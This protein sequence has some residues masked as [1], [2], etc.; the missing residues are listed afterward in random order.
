MSSY[1]NAQTDAFF[2]DASGAASRMPMGTKRGISPNPSRPS[3]A[4]QSHN[5]KQEDRQNGT[6]T[7]SQPLPS[8]AAGHNLMTQVTLVTTWLRDSKGARWVTFNDIADYLSIHDEQ[9]RLILQHI[10]R[11]H[12][13]VE[14]QKSP[15]NG[16]EQYRFKPVHN[17]RSAEDLL[18]VLQQ[19]TTADGIKMQE[20]REGWAGALE[21]VSSLA[22]QGLVLVTRNK[23]DS[24][25][26]R[27]WPS[28]PSL[29]H[30][31]DPEF[32]DI[33]AKLRVPSAKAD[34]RRELLDFGLMPTAQ[35]K[36]VKPLQKENGRKKRTR[37]GGK[38]TNTHM[39]AVLQNFDHLRK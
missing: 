27:V 2:K 24:Q 31:V 34:L 23:K 38:V 9:T 29:I 36:V 37:R 1:L 39:Q 14:F 13:K 4:P 11:Q 25:P 28:D 17:V 22:S 15:T 3:P 16:E 26:K 8:M 18:A 35:V 7:Y 5:V 6:T 33:W 19:R 10:L 20:L 21:A 32:R 12:S 30:P